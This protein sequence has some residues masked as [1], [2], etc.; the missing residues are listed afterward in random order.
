MTLLQW[1]KSEIATCR[2]LEWLDL[3]TAAIRADV[4]AKAE[5]LSDY[6]DVIELR[7][8]IVYQ[9]RWIVS[10]LTPAPEPETTQE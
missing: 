5:Y 9:R 7:W 3:L 1:L 6:A 2:S 4:K 10:Q 8:A